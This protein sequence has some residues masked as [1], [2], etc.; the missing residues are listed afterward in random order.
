LPKYLIPSELLQQHE[1]QVL[2]F[3]LDQTKEQVT[4]LHDEE[5][6]DSR[7]FSSRGGGFD[8]N[9]YD[10][11]SG[12]ASNNQNKNPL[13]KR[14]YDFQHEQRQQFHHLYNDIHATQYRQTGGN[15]EDYYDMAQSNHHFKVMVS[16]RI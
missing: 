7:I 13:Q 15:R 1:D 10:G 4:S 6:T 5:H 14:Q 3:F 11:S 2:H 16:K 8:R 9:N 12:P